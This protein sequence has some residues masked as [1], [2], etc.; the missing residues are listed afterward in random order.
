MSWG[1]YCS[2]EA[3]DPTRF[4]HRDSRA[5]EQKEKKLVEIFHHAKRFEGVHRYGC[6]NHM[7]PLTQAKAAL[8]KQLGLQEDA[9]TIKGWW[10]KSRGE[11]LLEPREGQGAVEFGL[12]KLQEMSISED[13]ITFVKFWK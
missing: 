3:Q 9:T 7:I 5:A 8:C 1:D 2:Y 12:D 10:G 11:V 4:S 13:V 6:E